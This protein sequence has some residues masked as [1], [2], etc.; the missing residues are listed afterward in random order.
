MAKINQQIQRYG[1]SVCVSFPNE[2]SISLQVA[3]ASFSP[4][5]CLCPCVSIDELKNEFILMK[6]IHSKSM[7]HN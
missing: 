2:A 4:S 5:D 3:T 7:E 6:Y 1:D